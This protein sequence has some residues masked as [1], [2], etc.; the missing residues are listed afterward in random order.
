MIQE[1]ANWSSARAM[2]PKQLG[3]D[4]IAVNASAVHVRKRNRTYSLLALRFL[5]LRFKPYHHA[6]SGTEE[7]YNPP[8]CH[9]G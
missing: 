9:T 3:H 4:G 5:A 7:G 8:L 1:N 6:V 2:S